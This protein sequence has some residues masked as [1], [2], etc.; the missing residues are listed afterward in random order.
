MKSY[1]ELIPI[2]AKAHRKQ[3]KMSIF[4]IVL[5]VFLVTVIFGMADMFVRSQIIQ[6]EKEYGS[7]HINL[8]EISDEQ[9]AQ[10]ASRPD[11]ACVSS[12]GVIN[13]R[14]DDGYTLGGKNVAICGSDEC[15]LTQMQS[16]TNVTGIFPK[17]ALQALVTENTRDANSLSIGD[18]ITVT[19]ADGKELVFTVSGFMSNSAKLMSEDSYGLFLNTNGFRSIYPNP[20][21]STA[22]DYSSVFFVKFSNTGNI[23]KS[24]D[25]IC[26]SL[27]ISTEQ[28]SENTRLMAL[29]GQGSNS[30]T[31]QIYAAASVLFILVMIAGVLMI[32]SSLN[33]NVAN[34]TQF[35]GMMRCIGATKKQVKVL[36]R[37]EALSWCAI[38]IP[39]GVSAGIILIWIICLMLRI[40]SPDYFGEMPPLAISWPSIAAGCVLGLLTVL[41][42]SHTPANRASRVSPL[43]AASGNAVDLHS[44][45]KAANTKLFK[46]DTAIGIQHAWESK[47]NY[48]L[49]SGSFALSIILFLSF[50][51]SIDFMNHALNSLDPWTP[52]LS[53]SSQS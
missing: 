38:A 51:V 32:A 1:L 37:R 31:L 14:G 6:T 13:Y 40:L 25:N 5:A 8:R 43:T 41:L 9:A 28:V 49:M 52:D 10:I 46:I 53:I 34:Q 2:S 15:F 22:A 19:T 24:I 30:F 42:A 39:I 7:W 16:D 47:K 48:L 12:Y 17:I 45:V 4:C 23:Q 36:V 21:G 50:S 33:S 3:N 20:N 18:P 29:L 11:V 44:A 26:K 35:Y 27:N